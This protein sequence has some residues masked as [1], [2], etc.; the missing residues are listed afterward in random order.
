MLVLKIYRET[1]DNRD[2]INNM[3]TNAPKLLHS[4]Y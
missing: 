1:P 3:K 4:Q 2:G